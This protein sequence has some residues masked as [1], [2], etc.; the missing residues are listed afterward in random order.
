[1]RAIPPWAPGGAH[2]Q[3][4]RVRD[5]PPPEGPPSRRNTAD[6]A[7]RES[8]P[9]VSHPPPHISTVWRVA[10]VVSCRV[11]FG[12]TYR[13]TRELPSGYRRAE[14]PPPDRWWGRRMGVVV[15][16]GEVSRESRI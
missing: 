8:V 3:A 2:R 16:G 7:A 9:A 15:V 1:L 4:G 11:L 12:Q 5:I 6:T 10:R 13:T 14:S